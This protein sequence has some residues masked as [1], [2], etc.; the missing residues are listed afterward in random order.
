M[1][2]PSAKPTA[3]AATNKAANS[4]YGESVMG[5]RNMT[6]LAAGYPPKA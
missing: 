6:R 4:R 3:M 2:L 1:M 5:A